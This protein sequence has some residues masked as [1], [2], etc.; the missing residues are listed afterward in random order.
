MICESWV[1]GV[2]VLGV[3]GV[4]AC[5]YGQGKGWV[6]GGKPVYNSK[7]QSEVTTPI[8]MQLLMIINVSSFNSSG[9]LKWSVKKNLILS[10][11]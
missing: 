7:Q 4:C 10:R 2:G 8:I 1:G 11:P 5:T 9:P 6:G 3:E